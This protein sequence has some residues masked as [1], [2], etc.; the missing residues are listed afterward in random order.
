MG[1][2]YSDIDENWLHGWMF[3]TYDENKQKWMRSS[4]R[5]RPSWVAT[6][7][8]RFA[9]SGIATGAGGGRGSA[10]SRAGLRAAVAR[11]G[12]RARRG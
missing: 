9:G 12:V 4:T 8:A 11:Y 10:V 3:Q 2:V 7:S 1:I 5:V 6:C